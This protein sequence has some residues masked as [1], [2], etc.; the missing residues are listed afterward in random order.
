MSRTPIRDGFRH[1]PAT[2]TTVA[3]T[4]T[5]EGRRRDVGL[6]LVPSQGS[7]GG[8]QTGFMG[9]KWQQIGITGGGRRNVAPERYESR[10]RAHAFHTT[11][12]KGERNVHRAVSPQ[13]KDRK[14]LSRSP[15]IC[16][17]SIAEWAPNRMPW[18]SILFPHRQYLAISRRANGYF[19][20]NAGPSSGTGLLPFP[21]PLPHRVPRGPQR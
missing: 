4:T 1:R 6:G 3:R 9:N 12:E 7:G 15:R 8:V 13:A 2:P 20:P 21:A 11:M 5:A 18:R 14:P 19:Q 17:S 10:A 16:N